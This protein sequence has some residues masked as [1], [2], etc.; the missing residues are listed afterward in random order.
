MIA[1]FGATGQTGSELT[2]Q[3]AAKGI[4]TRALLRNPEKAKMLEGLGVEIVQADLEQPETLEAA[5]RGAEKAYFVTSGGATTLSQHFYDAAK[6]AGVKH[7]VRLSGS[8]M[9]REAHG[10]RF[11]EQ[12]HQAEL[13][14][15]ASG[16]AWT[17]L[18]PSYF[19]Q[20]ILFQGASGTLALPLADRPVNLVD[21]RDIAAVAVA[22]LTGEGHAGQVYDI[23]GPQ[24]L[25]F[26]EVA[27]QLT[28]VTGRTFTYVPVSEAEF[29]RAL[30][31]WGLSAPVAADL[32]REYA[33]IGAGHPAFGVVKDTVPRLTGS[34]ARSVEQFARD[35][36][37][38]LV[39]PPRWG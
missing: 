33:L 32:A 23:T 27:A 7:I 1:V 38:A 29:A 39:N 12:H 2:R 22:A 30:A 34:P 10:I 17:H 28:A 15:E 19:M 13:A 37:Q 11:D 21:I 26:H 8:F 6:R 35:Y 25:T 24:A 16:L 5:L 3:L 31:Q 18:R 36:A 9:T 14:L 4:A 20:N